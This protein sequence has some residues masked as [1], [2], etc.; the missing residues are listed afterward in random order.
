MNKIGT[1]SPQTR[2]NWL[3]DAVL[4]ISA[5]IASLSGIYFLFLPIG[6]FQ[7]GRNPM[8]GVTVFFERST[9][10]DLHTWGGIFMITAAAFHVT[11]HWDWIVRMAKRTVKELT[12]RNKN[13]N[14]CGRF[15]A[16]I[17]AI[18][19]VSFLVTAISAIYLLFFP[20]G[21][22][23]VPDPNILF[24]RTTWDLIHTWSAILMMVAAMVHFAIH[25]KWVTKVTGK[26]VSP[27]FHRKDRG[28]SVSPLETMIG[29]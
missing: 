2:N 9:W 28:T 19:G 16:G 25:W 26:I 5:L 6:G 21:A 17:V 29:K 8:Y 3:V 7:G 1:V 15:N 22:H 12:G 11:I 10:D 23:G 18:I 13:M 14:N 24:T 27:L 4:L 20:G